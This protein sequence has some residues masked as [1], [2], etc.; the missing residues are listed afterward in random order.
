MSRKEQVTYRSYLLRLWRDG[1]QAPW[2]A[3][4]QST[5]TGSVHRF[6]DLMALWAFLETQLD[7]NQDCSDAGGAP[8]D[9][10]VRNMTG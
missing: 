3:S 4:L 6:S 1:E 7:T 9:E 2:R 10:S 8:P 5:R